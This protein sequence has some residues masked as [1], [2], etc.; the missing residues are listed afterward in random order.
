M[1]TYIVRRILAVIPVMAVVLLFVFF[2]LRLPGGADPAAI[3]AGDYA[4][5]SDI[6]RIRHQLGL[7][8]PIYT[9]LFIWLKKLFLQGD[10]GISIFSNLPVT[11]LIGQRIEPTLALSLTTKSPNFSYWLSLSPWVV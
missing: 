3:I 10:L 5:P 4:S 9:Q 8:E 2:M 11:K 7:D 1:Q 6:E